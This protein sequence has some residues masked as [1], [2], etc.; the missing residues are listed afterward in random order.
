[1]T[2]APK[3]SDWFSESRKPPED[4]GVDAAKRAR[5]YGVLHMLANSG[6][7]DKPPALANQVL[8][9]HIPAHHLHT[10]SGSFHTTKTALNSFNTDCINLEA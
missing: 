4:E 1:M 9:E 3:E 8:L 2:K 5:I 6:L 10:V 7:Q